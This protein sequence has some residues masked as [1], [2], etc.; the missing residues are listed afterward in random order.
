MQALRSRHGGALI[1]YVSVMRSLV[2]G[3]AF[4]APTVAWL[5]LSGGS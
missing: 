3:L 1:R 5:L 4:A 2:G